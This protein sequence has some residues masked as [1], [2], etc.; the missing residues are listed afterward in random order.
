MWVLQEAAQFLCEDVP[1]L[2]RHALQQLS[3]ERLRAARHRRA[4]QLI[5][6]AQRNQL[7][8]NVERLQEARVV[9]ECLD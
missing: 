9:E 8:V 2:L 1:G 4:L 6:Q 3:D 7:V 5:G